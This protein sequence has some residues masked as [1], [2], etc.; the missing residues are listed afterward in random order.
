MILTDGER[1]SSGQDWGL[2]LGLGASDPLASISTLGPKLK[3]G[4]EE[5]VSSRNLLDAD[6]ILSNGHSCHEA[7]VPAATGPSPPG[8]SCSLHQYGDLLSPE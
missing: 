1:K 6:R 5:S 8:M 7:V 3:Q 4:N 2:D